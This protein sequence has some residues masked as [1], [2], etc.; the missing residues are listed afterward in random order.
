MRLLFILLLFSSSVS[1]A[2]IIQ[3]NDWRQITETVGFTW[4]EVATVCP[5]GGGVCSGSLNSVDF[6]GW[7]WANTQEVGELFA[8]FNS[9]FT[10]PFDFEA[11]A[12]SMWAPQIVSLFTPNLT[13]LNLNRVLGYTADRAGTSFARTGD[14]VDE[15]SATDEDILRTNLIF[16][17]DGANGTAPGVWLFTPVPIPAAFWLFISAIGILGLLRKR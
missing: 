5:E 8:F 1:H 10:P 11:E 4:S 9:N 2:V 15:I 17:I 14:I 6:T 13:A 3:G 12:D 7:R 16:D